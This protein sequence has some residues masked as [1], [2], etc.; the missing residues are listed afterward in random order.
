MGSKRTWSLAAVAGVLSA[1]VAHQRSSADGGQNALNQGLN[2][3][4]TPAAAVSTA[5]VPTSAA[6]P[7]ARVTGLPDFSELVTQSGAAVVNIS[8]TEKPHKTGMGFGEPG[9]SGDDDPLSQFFRRHQLPGPDRAP[10]SH[11]IGSGFIISSDGYVLTNAHV[12]AD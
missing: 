2:Q 10:P 12:V 7:S 11:G 8:V 1:V 5:P 3:A 6:P 9:E 4:A